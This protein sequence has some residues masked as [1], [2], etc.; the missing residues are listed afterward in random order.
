MKK[1]KTPEEEVQH[2]AEESERW[3]VV[4]DAA[5]R[6]VRVANNAIGHPE[7]LKEH[8]DVVESWFKFCSALAT[9]FPGVLLRLDGQVV[10]MYVRLGVLGLSAQERFS[11][12]GTCGFFVSIQSFSPRLAQR[13]ST[14]GSVLHPV[15][16]G[17]I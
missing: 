13:V 3:H 17:C 1:S 6:L 8:P 16:G 10:E 2:Q 15:F 14:G 7:G 12:T 4:A 9:R 5:T 11:L